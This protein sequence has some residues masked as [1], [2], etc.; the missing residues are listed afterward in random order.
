MIAN[1]SVI[2]FVAHGSR[3][4]SWRRPIEQLRDAVV[5]A[6]AIETIELAYLELCEPSLEAVVE[7]EYKKGARRFVILPLFLSGGGHV[8]RDLVPQIDLCKS[9]FTDAGF[10]QLDA[11]GEL[12]AV[13]AALASALVETV[14]GEPS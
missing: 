3:R 1:E 8:A 14:E 5:N 4:D 10:A 12:P 13:H 6:M 7:K 2:I 9:R 11:F